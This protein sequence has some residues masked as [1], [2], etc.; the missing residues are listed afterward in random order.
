MGAT[1]ATLYTLGQRVGA[2]LGQRVGAALGQR[3]GAT[4]WDNVDATL[5]QRDSGG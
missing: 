2:A 3:V 1:L 4:R 5:T